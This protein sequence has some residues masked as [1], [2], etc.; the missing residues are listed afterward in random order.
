MRHIIGSAVFA[1]GVLMFGYLV[2]LLLEVCGV[3]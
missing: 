2:G 1:G 3:G